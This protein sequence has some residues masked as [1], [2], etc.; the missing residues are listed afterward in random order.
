[1]G[2]QLA[3]R[4]LDAGSTTAARVGTML[5]N[6]WGCDASAVDR[7]RSLTTGAK[8]ENEWDLRPKNSRLRNQRTRYRATFAEDAG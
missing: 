6:D 5:E 7:F 3:P 4:A 8:L 1:M 2:R